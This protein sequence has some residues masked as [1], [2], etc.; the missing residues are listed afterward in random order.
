ML[1]E[2]IEG[3]GRAGRPC[4]APFSDLRRRVAHVR[5][6]PAPLPRPGGRESLGPGT[7]AL[8]ATAAH[9]LG[10]V[11]L[12]G[13]GRLSPDAEDHEQLTDLLT[14][15]LGLGVFTANTRV[16]SASSH[17]GLTESFSIRR[18]GY[19]GQPQTGYALALF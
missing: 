4:R 19:L 10:H 18:L 6:G 13:Q 3:R 15:F 11:L 9:E 7:H 5:L 14:V 2:V 8:A 17:E 12:L 1:P 16:R